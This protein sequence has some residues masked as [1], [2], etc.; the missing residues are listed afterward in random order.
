MQQRFNLITV[1]HEVINPFEFFLLVYVLFLQN[2]QF[3]SIAVYL[4]VVL[5]NNQKHPIK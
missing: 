2:C 5:R 4:V 1:A 3:H